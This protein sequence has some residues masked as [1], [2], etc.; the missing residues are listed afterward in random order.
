[1]YLSVSQKYRY[2]DDGLR[3]NEISEADN[4]TYECRAEVD[5]QGSLRVWEVTLSVLCKYN[6]PLL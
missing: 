6:I 4:G 5:S 2:E 1:M 3:I